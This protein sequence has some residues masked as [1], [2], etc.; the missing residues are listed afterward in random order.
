[1]NDS[2][3]SIRLHF[4]DCLA[5]MRRTFSAFL[6]NEFWVLCRKDVESISSRLESPFACNDPIGSVKGSTI[7]S[8]QFGSNQIDGKDMLTF[9]WVQK[10]WAVQNTNPIDSKPYDSD[11]SSRLICIWST[12]ASIQL[13]EIDLNQ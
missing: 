13:S 1:M 7:W 3:E 11:Q 8:G 4:F 6:E 10:R 12:E 5:E 9:D 2:T